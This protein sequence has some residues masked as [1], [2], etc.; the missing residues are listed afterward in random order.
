M[1]NSIVDNSSAWPFVKT[2]VGHDVIDS[3]SNRAAEL[4]REGRSALPLLVWARQQTRGRGRGSHEWWSDAGSLTFT[5]A[6]DPT[7]HGLTVENEPKLALATAVAVID[8]LDQLGLGAPSLGIR[9]PNDLEA[10]GKKLGGILPERIET[11]PG[12]RILIGIGL[13][14][15]TDLAA[16]PAEVRAMATSLE[17]MLTRALGDGTSTRLIPAILVHFE[18]V[19]ERLVRGEP[20]LASRWNQLDLLRDRWVCV[21]QGTRQFA[22]RV[23]GIDRQGALCLDDGRVEHH[24]LG[25][26]VLRDDRPPSEHPIIHAKLMASRI[27]CGQVTD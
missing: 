5:L 3:T 27:D 16:A 14:V 24:I 17:A 1:T 23:I 7:R 26:C 2:A 21:D 13:N 18:S 6:L 20:A 4:L 22:G 12:H 19:L 25:G 9:W 15:R 8:A 11:E 10:S